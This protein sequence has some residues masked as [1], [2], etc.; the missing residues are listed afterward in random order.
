MPLLASSED[1]APMS[2]D[3]RSWWPA[4]AMVR[5]PGGRS[6]EPVTAGLLLR[7]PMMLLADML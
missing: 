6:E 2:A 4:V 1:E 5:E 7:S 3:A